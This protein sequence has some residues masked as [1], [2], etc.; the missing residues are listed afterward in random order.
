VLRGAR[1][2]PAIIRG[3]PLMEGIGNRWMDV[4]C[5]DP[6]LGFNEAQKRSLKRL[7][8]RNST[9]TQ[10]LLTGLLPLVA[11]FAGILAPSLVIIWILNQFGIFGSGVSGGN[12]G[13]GGLLILIVVFPIGVMIFRFVKCAMWRPYLNRAL[14]VLLLEQCAICGYSLIGQEDKNKPCPECGAVPTSVICPV[15]GCWLRG[16]GEDVKNCPECGAAR[17][18]M[19]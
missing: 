14:P 19:T 4:D 1:S 10:V 18:A 17:E 9:G 16:L 11:L 7:A 2:G 6:R 8:L 12:S 5:V 3:D 15:C 13:T